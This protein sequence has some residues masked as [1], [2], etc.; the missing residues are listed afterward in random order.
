[1]KGMEF[2]GVTF[3]IDITPNKKKY[4][5]MVILAS[6]NS[7]VMTIAKF[8]VNNIMNITNIINNYVKKF[9]EKTNEPGIEMSNMSK[10][11]KS[12]KRRRSRKR[13]SRRYRK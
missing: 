2:D 13:R 3:R 5:D 9:R 10:G 1:M 11:G 12:R 8:K 7:E 4:H 6:K